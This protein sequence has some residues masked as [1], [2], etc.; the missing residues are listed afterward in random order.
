MPEQMYKAAYG[1]SLSQAELDRRLNAM[2]ETQ[3]LTLKPL[4][5]ERDRKASD[6]FDFRTRRQRIAQWLRDFWSFKV[7][8]RPRVIGITSEGVFHITKIDRRKPNEGKG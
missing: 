7:M 5:L 6:T 1:I 4:P 3:M 8:R 2:L